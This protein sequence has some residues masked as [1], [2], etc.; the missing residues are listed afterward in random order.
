[1]KPYLIAAL[2]L[3]PYFANAQDAPKST[4]AVTGLAQK[5]FYPKACKITFF[6]Q[7]EVKGENSNGTIKTSLDSIRQNFF[8]NV[9]AYGLKESD[10]LLLKKSSMPTGYGR[11]TAN[12]YNI[13]YQLKDQK[14][15]VAQKI[16]D[17][18]R[19]PGLK[20]IVAKPQYSLIPKI[21]LDSLYSA[22]LQD[23]HSNAV[24]L[25]KEVNKTIGEAINVST[26]YNPLRDLNAEYEQIDTYSLSKFEISLVD[27]KTLPVQVTIT[28]ELKK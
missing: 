26:G 4:I 8:E 28:Y 20:G 24:S 9:K 22:A 11:S 5:T 14:F 17:D 27:S 25:A 21:V 15:N 16:V 3:L 12:L 13:A 6:L 23:A 1:M 18:L 19:V 2:L 10:F 7:E